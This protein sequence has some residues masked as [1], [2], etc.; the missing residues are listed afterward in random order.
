MLHFINLTYFIIDRNTI[1]KHHLVNRFPD[2]FG[3][4]TETINDTTKETEDFPP[5]LPSTTVRKVTAIQNTKVQ[6]V[7][8]VLATVIQKT[9]HSS[10][11]GLASPRG[12]AYL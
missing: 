4:L 2:Y 6:N 9:G 1:K 5:D 11:Q 8:Q 3:L 10:L 7:V 12:P